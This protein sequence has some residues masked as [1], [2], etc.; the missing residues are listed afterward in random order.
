MRLASLMLVF[1]SACSCPTPPIPAGPDVRLLITP[2][3]T[4]CDP[5]APSPSTVR[6]ATWNMAA[7][8]LGSIAD[9]AGL[10]ASVNA[11]VILL[12]EVDVGVR[13]SGGVNEP[14]ALASQLGFAYA[15][16]EA[17][18]WDGGHFGLATLSRLP[19]GAVRRISLD[20][21]CASERRI[22]L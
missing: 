21:P 4:T 3:L 6:I 16:G 5:G 22:G 13:R 14:E 7:G 8:E 12:Q 20:A 15:F 1:L 17:I 9:L 19:F 11:D 2:A 18:P 10:L